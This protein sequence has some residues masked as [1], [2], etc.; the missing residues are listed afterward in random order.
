[1]DKGHW[2]DF[3]YF[4]A[5]AKTSSIKRAAMALGTTQSAVS[6][7]LDKLEKVLGVRLVDRTATGTRLTYQGQRVLNHAM[8]AEVSLYRARCDATAADN[9]VEGDCSILASDGIANYWMAAYLDSFFSHYPDLELKIML[10]SG[11]STPRSELFD[12]RLHYHAPSD[13]TLV[14]KTLGTVHFMPFA[15]RGYIERHG[16]PKSVKELTEHRLIDQAQ[17]LISRGS[18]ATWF[19]SAQLKHTALFT[20]Q[21]AFL[22]RAVLSGAGIALM[23]TYMVLVDPG[24]VPIDIDMHFSLRLFV[25]FER[26]RAKKQAVRTTLNF[27]RQ[28]MFDADAMPWFG[29]DFSLPDARWHIFHRRSLDQAQG[30]SPMAAE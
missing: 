1:M 24:F 5:V 28:L 25:S 21:S 7:R 27:L 23:P 29:E 2:D 16:M 17:Y 8:A 14:A 30:E 6:K 20:N 22:A 9:R 10:D 13:V 11:L 15:S 4:L 26:E 19:E 12:L 18:W 3:R